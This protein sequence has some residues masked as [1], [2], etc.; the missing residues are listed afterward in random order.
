M[1]D[2]RG[3]VL[4]R[5]TAPFTTNVTGGA[6]SVSFV[7]PVALIRAPYRVS[8][9]YAGT[10]RIWHET[11]HQQTLL[12]RTIRVRLRDAATSATLAASTTALIHAE[13]HASCVSR[14]ATT[15]QCPELGS[16]SAPAA[17]VAAGTQ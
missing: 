12:P 14:T 11:W 7:N 15:A 6:D 1:S 13:L 2:E 3:P 9:S 10:D 8:F 16:Q 17:N 4:V 5:S